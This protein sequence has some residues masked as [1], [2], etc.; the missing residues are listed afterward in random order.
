MTRCVH[1]RLA[2]GCPKTGEGEN[3]KHKQMTEK[4]QSRYK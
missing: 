1:D 4:G 2:G 3:T